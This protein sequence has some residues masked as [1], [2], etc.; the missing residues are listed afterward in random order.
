MIVAE[1]ITSRFFNVLRLFNR[2]VPMIY[3]GSAKRI[4]F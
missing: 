2:S 3:C 1:Q 4:S